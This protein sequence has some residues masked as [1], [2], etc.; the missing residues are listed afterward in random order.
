MKNVWINIHDFLLAD[1]KREVRR[2]PTEAALSAY[3]LGSRR[4]YP[5]KRVERDSP[6]KLLLANILYPRWRKGNR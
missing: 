5:K 4:V 1:D 6:L 3:T 2:F